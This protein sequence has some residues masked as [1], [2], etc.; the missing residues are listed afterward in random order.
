MTRTTVQPPTSSLK[1]GIARVD[2][3][4]PVGIYHPLWGAARHH[5]AT[6]IHRPLTAEIMVF[7][8]LTDTEHKVPGFIRVQ[9]DLPGLV[10][11]Q[12]ELLR[13]AVSQ[14]SGWST[15][16]IIISYS[17]THAAG[18]FVPDRFELPGGDLIAPY[19][20]DL[21]QKLTTTTQQALKHTQPVVMTYG[22]GHC[23]LAANRD[24][25]DAERGVY[26]CGFNPE[27][28]ADDTVTVVRVTDHDGALVAVIVN[29]ACHPTTLAWEN[30]LISPD[31]IGAMRE[32]VE[33]ATG[34]LCVFTLGACGDLGP[35]EG[36]VG[37]TAV[38]D[39]N[40]R[41]LGYAALSV[42]EA[43]DAPTTNYSYQGPVISGA[44]LGI[45]KLEALSEDQLAQ[46]RY[47]SGN[48]ASLDLACKPKPDVGALTQELEEWQAEIAAAD[49]YGDSV[50][51]RDATARAERARRW[52]A[53]LNDIPD[54]EI[55]PYEYTVYRIGDAIWITCGG[56]PYNVIVRDLRHRFPQ[57]PIIFSPV[58]GD[59]Q[60]AYLLPKDRYGQGLYQEEPSILAPGCLEILTETIAEWIAELNG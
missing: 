14:A 43:M 47:F 46:T 22:F 55:L 2:I 54:S 49:A 12:H 33:Q 3:T 32:T 59:L 56:E 11:A 16:Q 21:A 7:E 35:R 31:Y 4:P 39:R 41:Q 34:T 37:D 18:W 57:V 9:L 48:C 27:I 8:P 28:E 38:A 19:L 20:D 44:T 52:L 13:Q 24:Y 51:A 10:K 26:A 50:A 53:R 40:G 15:E 58:S 42:L 29:Y 5:Q 36:F 23:S 25:W 30:T 45:W 60:V 6:G 1:F 17:H